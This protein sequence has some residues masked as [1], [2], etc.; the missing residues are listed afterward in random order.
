[1]TYRPRCESHHTPE[2]SPTHAP[3]QASVQWGWWS[4]VDIVLGWAHL[5]SGT[6][7]RRPLGGRA[8]SEPRRGSRCLLTST[9]ITWPGLGTIADKVWFSII[10]WVLDVCCRW[11]CYDSWINWFFF[12]KRVV[13]GLWRFGFVI[14]KLLF[15]FKL[16]NFQKLG[17]N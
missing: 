13:L 3:W 9:N 10:R 7:T 5:S 14:R 11:K 8:G 17:F 12:N 15:L 1:M 4:D 6:C 2:P 16:I